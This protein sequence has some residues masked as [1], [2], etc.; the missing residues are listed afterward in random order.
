MLDTPT[1]K[2]AMFETDKKSALDA[3]SHAQFIAFAPYIFQASVILRDSGILTTIEKARAEGTTID[4][5]A[6]SV[7]MSRYG[8][9]ILMEAGLGIGLLYKKEDKYYLAK[10]G[11]FFLNDAMTRVNTD[12]MRDVCYDGAQDL[13]ASIEQGKPIGLRHLGNWE[14]IY[15]G[16]S[17]LPEPAKESWFNFDHY[18][19][20]N[21]FPEAL[22]LVFAHNPKKI[23]DIGANTGK[24][25]LACLDYN[26]EV[27]V[28]LVDLQVQ[29][30]VAKQNIEVAGYSHRV[31][32]HQRNVL[33]NT[34]ELPEGYDIIWM[35][36]FLDC[37]ADD[38][39]VSILQKC[40]R[41]LGDNGRVFINETF[42]DKQRFEASAL[43]LQMT[44]LYFTTMA[45]G[46]S[47]MYDSHVFMKLIDQAGFE[48][49]QQTD[50]VGLSHT[51]LELK[52]K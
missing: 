47:Q 34:T 20:D 28:G 22:P 26:S 16:L 21:A 6:A 43:S 1:K 44:S 23:M 3:I 35:S 41:A 2:P 51:I 37:F 8:V 33:D 38:E 31:Q 50:N 18:Y 46:N 36:Q 9:R 5:V 48:V 52:K 17:I 4:E 27:E 42:W 11:H 29:L 45:N 12:F 15:Q 24:F 14:T 39:I 19:S 49:V 10:T 32:Y 25:T 30:N 40:Y 13:K 7:K